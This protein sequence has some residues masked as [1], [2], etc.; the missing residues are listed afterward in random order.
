MYFHGDSEFF[1]NAKTLL[2]LYNAFQKSEARGL[3]KKCFLIRFL[4]LLNRAKNPGWQSFTQDT[5]CGRKLV[6]KEPWGLVTGD[7]EEVLASSP[8]LVTN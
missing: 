5:S 4:Q 6:H 7:R 1:L 8:D 2:P 3:G